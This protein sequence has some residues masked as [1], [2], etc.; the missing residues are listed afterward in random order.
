MKWG[1]VKMKKSEQLAINK[2]VI[3]A[4]DLFCAENPYTWDL[5]FKRLYSCSAYVAET[6]YFIVLKSYDTIIAVL[7]KTNGCIYDFLRY[8][9]GYTAISAQHVSKFRRYCIEH[10]LC[11]YKATVYTYREV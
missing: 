5:D 6:D 8:V 3:A 1:I 7:E 11:D 9:Y 2:K 10:F 4:Y